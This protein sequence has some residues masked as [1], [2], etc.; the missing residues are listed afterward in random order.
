MC[1]TEVDEVAVSL[2]QGAKNSAGFISWTE[3]AC[4]QASA[5][6]AVE[7]SAS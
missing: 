4:L 2:A 3:K 7:L 1:Q 6:F 5:C